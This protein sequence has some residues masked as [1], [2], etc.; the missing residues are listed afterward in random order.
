MPNYFKV[1]S[2]HNKDF[3]FLTATA[4]FLGGPFTTF[5]T[6]VLVDY[7]DKRSEM[8]IPMICLSK[9]LIDVPMLMLTYF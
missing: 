6:G 1:Y 4:S 2:H 9:A 7:F 5:I 3:S 8:T